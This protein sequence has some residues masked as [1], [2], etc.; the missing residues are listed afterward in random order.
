M[1]SYLAAFASSAVSSACECL[2]VPTP[3]TTLKSTSTVK[4]TT[5]VPYPTKTTT[6]YR[7]LKIP[8]PTINFPP[9][10]LKSVCNPKTHRSLPPACATPVPTLTPTLPYGLSPNPPATA[11]TLFGGDTVAGASLEGCCNL[12]YFGIDNCVQAYWYFFEGCVIRQAAAPAAGDGVG[13]STVCP[14]GRLAGLTY[15]R[16]SSP[17]FRS[18]GD[19]AGPCGVGYGNL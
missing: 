16:D 7:K 18:T 4:I 6:V 14:V 19:L 17:A 1:P 10:P 12:C 5:S 2:S 3:V 13:V 15:A 9:H 8:S 11:N